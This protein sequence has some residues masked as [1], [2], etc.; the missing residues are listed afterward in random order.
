MVSA[1]G[2]KADIAQ[3]SMN[4]RLRPKANNRGGVA[5][6]IWEADKYPSGRQVRYD[7]SAMPLAG[8]IVV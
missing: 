1:F 6:L 4:V 2:G 3:A 8:G 7:F 5:D